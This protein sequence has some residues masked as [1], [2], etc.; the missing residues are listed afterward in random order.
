MLVLWVELIFLGLSLPFKWLIEVEEGDEIGVDDS[1]R[2]M[3][4][5]SS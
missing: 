4:R 1:W 2:T 3:M 5:V